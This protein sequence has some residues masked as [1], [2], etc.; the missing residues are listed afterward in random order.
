M[1]SDDPTTP[2][3]IS[4]PFLKLPAELRNSIYRYAV[5]RISPIDI[6]ATGLQEPALLWVSKQI[7]QEAAPIFWSENKLRITTV[8]YNITAYM[9]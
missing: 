7:R 9:K 8:D 1:R 6:D 3:E 5:V 2:N 4:F